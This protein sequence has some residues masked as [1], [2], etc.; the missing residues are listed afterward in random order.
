MPKKKGVKTT[1]E[2]SEAAVQ[3]EQ[4]STDRQGENSKVDDKAD[5]VLN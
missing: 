1:N 4:T 5:N 3:D 2:Q